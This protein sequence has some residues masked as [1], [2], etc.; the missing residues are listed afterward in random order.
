M[1]KRLLFRQA[2]KH[3][4]LQRLWSQLHTL[5]IFGMNYGGG[6]LIEN[7]GEIWVLSNVI[8]PALENAPSPVVFDVGANVGDYALMVRRFVASARICAFEPSKRTFQ[9]LLQNIKA[10]DAGQQIEP[11]NIGFSDAE[12]L[13][14]LYSYTADGQEASLLSSIDLRLPTQV[15]DV[16]VESSEQIQ[17]R[18]IDRFCEEQGIKRIDFLKLDIEGHEV[19]ALRGATRM[20]A[21]GAISLIQFEF[22]PANIYSRTY[23]YDFWTL[24]ANR[25]DLYRIIPKGIVP[26]RY[27]GEHN[28]IFLTTNYLAIRKKNS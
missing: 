4:S 23:L 6:G 15:V 7:S 14:E 18:T 27:Y 17:V 25:Y 9:Q 24:L 5:T 28:E 12:K 20:L 11:F 8:K 10:A 19:A 1:L 3:P 13:I 2:T 26:L 16:K 22:G 21:D